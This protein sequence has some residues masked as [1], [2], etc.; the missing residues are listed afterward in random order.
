MLTIPSTS[1]G[2]GY[3]PLCAD[4]RI[5]LH[6]C[7]PCTGVWTL[8]GSDVQVY[9]FYAGQFQDSWGA[10]KF[11]DTSILSSSLAWVT[12]QLAFP[13]HSDKDIANQAPQSSC[14]MDFLKKVQEFISDLSFPEGPIYYPL[15]IS[16]PSLHL[17]PPPSEV[18]NFFQRCYSTVNVTYCTM[19]LMDTF[20]SYSQLLC[21]IT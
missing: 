14:T 4:D 13:V 12:A 11:K 21:I 1:P 15:Y 17:P 19:S 5:L 10:K 3:G 6:Q 7:E 20:C 18:S 9:G 16:L 8:S 2:S